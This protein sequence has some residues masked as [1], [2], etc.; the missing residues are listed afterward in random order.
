M[1][2][3]YIITNTN[4]THH[5]QPDQ[6]AVLLSPSPLVSLPWSAWLLLTRKASIA[7]THAQR[8]QMSL[9]YMR[10]NKGVLTA[11]GA[12]GSRYALG[13]KQLKVLAI[14]TL[15]CFLLSFGMYT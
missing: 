2:P 1:D 6:Q 15:V 10:V 7:I 9:T 14:S 11:E 5:Q 13:V 3:D 12:F 4:N 8:P